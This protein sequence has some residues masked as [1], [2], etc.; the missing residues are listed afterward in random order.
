MQLSV[1]I[2]FR[3][4]EKNLPQLLNCLRQQTYKNVEYIFVNDHSYDNGEKII[5]E[6]FFN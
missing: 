2:A 5:S 3:N 1:V 4:E 6:Q